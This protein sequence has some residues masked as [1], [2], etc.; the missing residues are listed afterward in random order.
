VRSSRDLLAEATAE[1][2]APESLIRHAVSE[3][4]KDLGEVQEIDVRLGGGRF[5]DFLWSPDLFT[6]TERLTV[7]RITGNSSAMNGLGEELSHSWAA[8]VGEPAAAISPHAVRLLG[9][10]TAAVDGGIKQAVECGALDVAEAR[11]AFRSGLMTE[12]LS[13]I[14]RRLAF[15]AGVPSVADFHEF[16]RAFRQLLR[17]RTARITPPHIDDARRVP[18]AKIY[19]DPT[20]ELKIRGVWQPKAIPLDKIRRGLF[21]TVL[22]GQPGGGKST[23]TQKLCADLTTHYD[24]RLVGGV[25]LTPL[26]VVLRDYAAA[27]QDNAGMSLVDYI[28]QDARAS[29]SVIAP[30]GAIEYL[31]QQGRALVIFDGLDEITEPSKRRQMRDV[32]ESFCARFPATRVLI[33]SREIGYDQAPLDENEFELLRLAEFDDEQVAEY[34]ENWFEV[35]P[36]LASASQ[37]KTQADAFV[38]ESGRVAADLRRNPLLL[39]LM[40]NLYKGEGYIPNN[41][42]EIYA[43]CS[44]ML[45]RRWDATRGIE[46]AR[47]LGAH[48]ERTLQH[49]AHWMFRQAGRQVGV[50]ERRLIEVA[51]EYLAEKRFEDHDEALVE[52]GQFLEFCK[53]R[54]WVL[55]KVGTRNGATLFQF[56]HR[57]FLEYFTAEY[58]VRT[59]DGPRHLGETLLPRLGQPSWDVVAQLAVQIQ[60]SYREGAGDE[61]L[62]QLLASAQRGNRPGHQ[63]HSSLCSSKPPVSSACPGGDA[64]RRWRGSRPAHSS[65]RSVCGRYGHRPSQPEVGPGRAARVRYGSDRRREPRRGFARRAR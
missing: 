48:L 56:A 10:L 52:A 5:R 44:N 13:S 62:T 35:H 21:R 42:P 15:L 47:P 3:A 54:A 50:A 12:L 37:R 25:A 40:C 33:T 32:L 17:N 14:D 26:V 6:L 24:D 55:V 46:V 29:Y 2:I 23:F 1:E 9:R 30:E 60:N 8:W 45:L 28:E 57:T 49:L 11:A 58:L 41:R 63:T 53:G 38:R 31:C 4:L 22:V 18:L 27:R 20:F 61:L 39:A 34:A 51:A 65:R 59:S 7:A 36:D 64:R 19:V 16:E 43:K